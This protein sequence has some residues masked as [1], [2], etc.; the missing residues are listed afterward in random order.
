V[1]YLNGYGLLQVYTGTGKGK[2]TAALGVAFRAAGRGAKT[3]VIQYMKD[4]PEYGEVMAAKFLPGFE[5]K[6]VGRASFVNFQNPDPIDMQML[7]DG[8]L[9]AQKAILS[10]EYDLIIL[11][12]INVALAYGLLN[13]KEIVEFLKNNLGH[14]EVIC[15][16]RGAP[17]ELMEIADL[18][19]D[20]ENK[21]HY[22][23]AGVRSRDGIDH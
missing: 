21:K 19:T 23:F 15:T 10:Q 4:D 9:L 11:D 17:V 13:V 1:L 14:T 20:M 7:K 18:T 16:G 5:L 6:Q 8:W 12:E 22:F 3:L 2:T